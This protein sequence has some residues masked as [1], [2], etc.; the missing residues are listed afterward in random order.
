MQ[1]NGN[2][3][4]CSKTSGIEMKKKEN[5]TFQMKDY[6]QNNYKLIM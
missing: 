1:C 5:N 3:Y 2:L 6:A 4:V